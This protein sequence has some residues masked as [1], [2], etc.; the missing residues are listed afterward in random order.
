[1]NKQILSK[2][3]IEKLIDKFKEEYEEDIDDLGFPGIFLEYEEK[4]VFELDGYKIQYHQY[5]NEHNN[6]ELIL[7]VEDAKTNES[8]FI[9]FTGEY[10]SWSGSDWS[11]D[12]FNI[13]IQKKERITRKY[14][15]AI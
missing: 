6:L 8:C 1:M 11:E 13:V 12:G 10:S 14:W 15:C 9:R 3:R 4:H 7:K 2:E 5:T